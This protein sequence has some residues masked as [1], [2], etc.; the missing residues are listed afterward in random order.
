MRAQPQL[1]VPSYHTLPDGPFAHPSHCTVQ[2]RWGF[3]FF[4]ESRSN[5]E[6]I[7][8]WTNK[9]H[10]KKWDEPDNTLYIV[11]TKEMERNEKKYENDWS[12]PKVMSS[13]FWAC[14]KTPFCFQ[15]KPSHATSALKIP[16]KRKEK[17]PGEKG[18]Y[19][20]AQNRTRK[21]W[22]IPGKENWWSRTP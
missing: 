17:N 2:A 15:L 13:S 19:N 20:A 3:P 12:Q 18:I 5:E 22:K 10:D 9:P 16:I 4:A 8:K 6:G 21:K 1:T 14:Q 11:I 7:Y